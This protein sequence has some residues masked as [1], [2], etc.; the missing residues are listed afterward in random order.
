MGISTQD[1]RMGYLSLTLYLREG[2]SLSGFMH[3]G[4]A[5]Y[6]EVDLYQAS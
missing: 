6:N 4:Y 3:P 2:A 5:R 1:G